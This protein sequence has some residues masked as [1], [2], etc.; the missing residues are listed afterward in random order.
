MAEAKVI[1]SVKVEDGSFESDMSFP[2]SATAA[3]RRAS[4]DLWIAML[5]NAIHVAARVEV[6]AKDGEA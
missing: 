3:E 6:P 1:V 2:V 4:L 5:S